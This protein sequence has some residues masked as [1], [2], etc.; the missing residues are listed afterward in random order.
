LGKIRDEVF[1]HKAFKRVKGRSK[2]RYTGSRISML[3]KKR[4]ALLHPSP[5]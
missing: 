5:F 1:C 4:G 2:P 3:K